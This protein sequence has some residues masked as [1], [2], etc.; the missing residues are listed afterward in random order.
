MKISKTTLILSG[1]AVG[2]VLI[3]S[4]GARRIASAAVGLAAET[5][6]GVVYG[7]SDVVGLQNPEKTAC[8]KAKEQ[9]DLW[10]ASFAC[11]A[12]EFIKYWW[13]K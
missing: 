7:V 13:Q 9:G 10:E 1:L 4:V 8:Q 2:G 3:Y 6:T 12:D 5:A 11:E